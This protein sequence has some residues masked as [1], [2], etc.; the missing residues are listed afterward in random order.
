M[1]IPH[2]IQAINSLIL[3]ISEQSQISDRS[4]KID[5]HMKRLS[6]KLKTE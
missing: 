5:I 4:E 1:N 2:I 6:M 3:Q